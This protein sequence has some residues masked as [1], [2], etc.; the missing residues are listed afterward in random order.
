IFEPKTTGANNDIT[1]EMEALK[2]VKKH[3]NVYTNLTA[4]RDGAFF[5]HYTGWVVAR[6]GA[7]P[8]L[9]NQA[10]GE[11]MDVTIANQIGRTTRFKSL[12]TTATG[13]VRTVVSYENATTP[14]PSEASPLNFY[15]RLFGPDFQDPNAPAFTP[16][17]RVMVRKSALSAVSDQIQTLNKK[18]GAEDKIRLEQY[19]SGLRHLEQQFDQQLTKPEPLAA[20]HP[21]KAPK[22]DAKLGNTAEL[23]Q[24]RHNMMT[25]LLVMAVACDQT[26]V[27]NMAYSNASSNTTKP[28]YDKPHHTCTHEEPRDE[29]LGYQPNASWYVRRSFESLAYFIN[30]FAKVKEGDGLLIDNVLIQA[31]TDVSYA[32]VHSLEE[33]PAFTAG[34]AGGRVKTGLHIDGKGAQLTRLSLTSMKAMGLDINSWGTKSNQASKEISEMLV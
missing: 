26:R 5:C 3:F 25:D 16:S 19:F 1:E 24:A 10:P 31:N 17:P 11:S 20:C 34:K 21:A 12:T 23:V 8:V 6:V 18:V 28:G 30:A 2:D 4:Y 33:M 32:R 27:F 13:D 9:N 22:E 29:K 15:T 14:N 7:S